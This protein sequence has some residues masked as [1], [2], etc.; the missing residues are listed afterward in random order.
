MARSGR[1]EEQSPRSE[2]KSKKE[3]AGRGGSGTQKKKW[4]EESTTRYAHLRV[5]TQNEK[6]TK[7]GE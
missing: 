2:I 1:G 6:K 4:T 7:F 3:N 5:K